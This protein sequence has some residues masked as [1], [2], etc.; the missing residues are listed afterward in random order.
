MEQS[1]A[2]A[3]GNPA[4]FCSPPAELINCAPRGTWQSQSFWGKFVTRSLPRHPFL[5]LSPRSLSPGW[6]AI[7]GERSEG[8]LTRSPGQGHGGLG[9]QAGPRRLTF[10]SV[11]Q[12]CVCWDV[13]RARPCT[14]SAAEMRS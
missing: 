2:G 13:W 6:S 11:S 10:A 14:A 5:L 9:T 8:S 12:L 1:G 3:L 7:P 4:R